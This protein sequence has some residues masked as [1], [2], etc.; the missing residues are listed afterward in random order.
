MIIN[1]IIST[2]LIAIL[3]KIRRCHVKL[4]QTCFLTIHLIFEANHI[5]TKWIDLIRLMPT[6]K[7]KVCFTT[8]VQTLTVAIENMTPQMNQHIDEIID[9]LKHSFI[10]NCKI[11]LQM[12]LIKAEQHFRYKF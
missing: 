10:F 2:V 6:D 8:D 4:E 7:V 5:K 1:E 12:D 11:E 3:P 9:H